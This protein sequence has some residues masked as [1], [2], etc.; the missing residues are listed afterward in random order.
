MPQRRTKRPT[1]REENLAGGTTMEQPEEGSRAGWVLAAV[2][3][4]LGAGLA[5]FFATRDREK[6][7]PAET[8]ESEAEESDDDEAP[9]EEPEPGEAEPAPGVA[10]RQPE[11]GGADRPSSAAAIAELDE[12]LRVQR[13]WAKVRKEGDVLVI[14][15]SLCSDPGMRATVS[16]EAGVL[17]ASGFA[18]VRCQEPNGKVDFENAI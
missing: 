6:P 17:R 14:E 2:L 13:L 10:P 11:P 7:P 16:D 15:S 5:I 18:T 9:V 1:F 4:V 12:A 8:V 3:L